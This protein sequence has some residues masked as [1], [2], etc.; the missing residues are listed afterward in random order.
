MPCRGLRDTAPF[1][2]D[3]IPG[4]PHGGINSA[5]IHASVD[6]NADPA[7]PRRR[8]GEMAG[9]ERGVEPDRAPDVGVTRETQ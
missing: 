6:A 7:D 1:H 8:P 2:W 3:G 9:D 4:D 5:S